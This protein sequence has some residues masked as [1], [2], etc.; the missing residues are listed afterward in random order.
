MGGGGTRTPKIS[1]DTLEGLGS[2]TETA[3]TVETGGSA[4][5]GRSARAGS[6]TT[7]G[8]GPRGL[9]RRSRTPL[10]RLPPPPRSHGT[11]RGRIPG[12]IVG[13]FGGRLG[14]R[15]RGS[16][17]DRK[18]NG[19][20]VTTEEEVL[21][22]AKR[23]NPEVIQR[24]GLLRR[25]PCPATGGA[26]KTGGSPYVQS[27]TSDPGRP[28]TGG[29]EPGTPRWRPAKDGH[30]H[31]CRATL[32]ASGAKHPRTLSGFGCESSLVRSSPLVSVVSGV[33]GPTTTPFSASPRPSVRPPSRS[34]RPSRSRHPS[35]V[36]LGLSSRPRPSTCP[37]TGVL[38]TER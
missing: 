10:P 15:K 37:L 21:R 3:P 23:G 38:T 36:V 1:F 31:R 18:E 32:G 4:L 20:G 34:Q 29:L 24:C 27:G 16:V 33:P 30:C 9:R 5:G 28:V 11:P 2:G 17:E 22:K 13:K 19:V 12:I 26:R 35:R 7:G 8:G 14:Q 6:T 25:L